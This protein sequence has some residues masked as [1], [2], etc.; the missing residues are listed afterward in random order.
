[1]KKKNRLFIIITIVLIAI[2]GLLAVNNSYLT[3]IRDEAADFSVWDTASVTKIYLADRENN[4]TLLERQSDG[5][6]L[7]EEYRAHSK[8]INQILYTL[9]KVRI[10]MPVSIAS[11]DNIIA[12][13]ASGSTKVEVYQNV[14][15]INIFNKIKL[16]YHEKLTKVFYVGD[17]TRDNSGTFML[18]EGA[19]KAYIVYIPG[20]RG[21][22]STRFTANPDDWRD[23]TIYHE[24]LA[25]IQS[26]TMEFGDNPDYSFRVDNTGKHNYKMTR[27][28]DNANVEFDTLKVINLL[29]SF[30]DLRFEALMN[31]VLPQKRIDSIVSS[32]FLNKITLVTKDG[33]T[34]EM[35]TFKKKLQLSATDPTPESEIEIDNDRMYGL[36][37]NGKDLVLIQYYIFDKVLKDVYYYEKGNPIQY[38]VQHYEVLD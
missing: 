5:W 36:V 2:A 19:K 27:L 33:K 10:R 1:M 17:A 9:F 15:R 12:D 24:T 23:H 28:A 34:Q 4:E 8:K 29:S 31:N 35:K 3:T 32:P 7:N 37:N 22:I 38:E 21:F 20:F 26:L 14:P 6:T 30:S 13:M 11:H 16:F 25:D 18:K